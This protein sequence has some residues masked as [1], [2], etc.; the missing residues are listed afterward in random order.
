MEDLL[1]I[2]GELGMV[3]GIFVRQRFFGLRTLLNA[4]CFVP[5]E[6]GESRCKDTPT[7]EHGD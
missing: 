3:R 6:Y 7:I 2:H 1:N 5:R 4:Y